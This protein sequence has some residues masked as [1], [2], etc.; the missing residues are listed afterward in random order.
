MKEKFEMK[1]A[2][3]NVGN[4]T[5]LGATIAQIE[6]TFDQDKFLEQILP[7]LCS[8]ELKERAI[9]IEDAL[10]ARLPSDYCRSVEIL[11]QA[12]PSEIIDNEVSGYDGFIIMPLTGYV[13]RLGMDDFVLSMRALHAMTK[14]FTAE[15]HIRYF[16]KSHYEETMAQLHLWCEDENVHVRRLVSEG[17]RPRLPWAFALERFKQDPT[18]VIALLTKLKNDKELYVR[19]SVANN[20]NDISKDHPAL[21]VSTL[22]IWKE[23][24]KEMNWLTKHA[25]RTLLKAGNVEALALLGYKQSEA[26]EVVLNV[27]Q[28][29]IMFGESLHFSVEITSKERSDLPIMIDY[30]IYYQKANGKLAPK[31]FKLSTKTLKTGQSITIDKKQKFADFSTRKHYAGAHEIAILINGRA[32]EKVAFTLLPEYHQSL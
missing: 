7:T 22:Q 5:A 19:R 27:K 30:V 8:L 32:Y 14:R 28:S 6:P 23:D 29:E 15:F 2:A 20:L 24:S 31:V 4:I 1:E 17:T 3:F 25:L 11:L 21:V 10:I 13:A 12:L 16:I 26:L 18:P 9:L